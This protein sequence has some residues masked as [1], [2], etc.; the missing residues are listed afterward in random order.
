VTL[1]VVVVEKTKI[2]F[3]RSRKLYWVVDES[4]RKNFAT[5]IGRLFE[6]AVEVVR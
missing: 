3:V 1:A 6:V 5:Q 2:S 4:T